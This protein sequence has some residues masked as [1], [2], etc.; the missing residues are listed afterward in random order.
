[1]RGWVLGAVL[2]LGLP[3]VAH[4]TTGLQWQWP[5]EGRRYELLADLT[6]PSLMVLQAD[7]N[8]EVRA[9]RVQ[10]DAITTCK[11]RTE[12]APKSGWILDC[13]IDDVALRVGI[14]ASSEGREDKVIPELDQKL[15]GAVVQVT[16]SPDGHIRNIDLEGVNKQDTRRAAIHENLR[17]I[18]SRAFSLLDF[19]MP[20]KGDDKG[21]GTWKVSDVSAV[22]LPSNTGSLGSLPVVNTITA[23]E[24]SIIA[25]TSE[26]KGVLASGETIVVGGTTQPAFTWQMTYKGESHFD[27]AKGTLLDRQYLS[28]GEPTASSFSA[29]GTKGQ[30]YLQMA[31]LTLLKATDTIDLGASGVLP[32]T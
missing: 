7:E 30:P 26:G 8:F 12:N 5:A 29:N 20:S 18:L 2:A 28:D 10:I 1:M 23:N 6:L 9:H 25:V 16:L 13:T 14:T 31:R 3:N 17:L 27:Y 22:D 19:E 32:P 15:T 4:A 11:P 21:K 24:N